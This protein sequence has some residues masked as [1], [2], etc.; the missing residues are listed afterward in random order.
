ME[1]GENTRFIYEFGK[2]VLDPNEKT[3]FADGEPLRLPAKEFETLVLLVENNGRALS[4]E[5]MMSA[6]WHDS[7]VEESNLAK[8]IS[9]LRK[10]INTNGERF[11]E[12]L[13]KHGYRFSADLRTTVPDSDGSIVLE[14]RTLRRFT[15]AVEHDLDEQAS[16]AM[17]KSKPFST[18][19][20]L[21][22]AVGLLAVAAFAFWLLRPAPKNTVSSIA[23]LPLQAIGSDSDSKELGLGLTDSLISKIGSLKRVI[24]RPTSAVAGFDGRTDAV[25]FGRRLGVDAVL[26]GTIQRE[27]GKLR[28][29]ARLLRSD[30]GEQIW[31][32]RFEQPLAG[33]FALQ[34]ALSSNITKALAFELT[35]NDSGH[36]LHRGTENAAAYEKYLR[37]RFYQ[38]QNTE[39]GLVRSLKFYEEAVGLDPNFAEAHAGIADSNV[40]LFNFNLRPASETVPLARQA[41][42]RALQ[43]N[44]DLS[45]AYSS[46][47]LIQ[48]LTEHNWPD[49]EKSLQKAIEL[50]PNNADAFVR[51]GYFLT[52]VGHFDEA[53]E[54]L[55]KARELNPLSPIVQSDIGLA[56]ICSRRHTEAVEELEKAATENP[57]F[58]MAKWFLATA[59]EA[60]GEDEKAFAAGLEALRAEGGSSLAERLQ[61]VHDESGVAVANRYWL[62]ETIESQKAGKDS[63]LN[64]A[65]RA[66]TL[67]DRDQTLYWIERSAEEKDPTLFG[68]K[69]LAKFDFVRDDPRFKAVVENLGS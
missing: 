23:V 13:P 53:L 11:I 47:A 27:A 45:N 24:V 49:A 14:K 50:D 54:K 31:S 2:F 7:F 62:D 30:T 35:K 29:N 67:R 16:P 33:I 28:V 57:Q 36:L 17:L 42:N 25:E 64:V 3:L 43:L 12:T 46:L 32:E 65:L 66:A 6:I 40:I 5:E 19:Q 63:A 34:D 60:S 1:S 44:P 58:S 52:N 39:Q 26:E 59:Y 20:I 38:S 18:R 4:K 56:Y 55:E 41:I 8:Q 68:I 9:R 61:R 10:I 69:Y 15:M 22:G 37:G 48:F 21:L 51:Y